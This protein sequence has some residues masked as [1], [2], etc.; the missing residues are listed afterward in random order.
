MRAYENRK[1]CMRCACHENNAT[2]SMVIP[3]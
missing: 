3:Q 2:A 1:P